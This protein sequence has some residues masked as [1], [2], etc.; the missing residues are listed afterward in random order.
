MDAISQN[1]DLHFEFDETTQSLNQHD[2]MAQHLLDFHSVEAM[3]AV[4]DSSLQRLEHEH[5]LE[6][7]RSKLR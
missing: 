6:E 5:Q 1:C 2:R 4:E 3:L 7:V